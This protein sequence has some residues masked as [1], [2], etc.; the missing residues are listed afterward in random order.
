MA[1]TSSYK[2]GLNDVL[3]VI[4]EEWIAG[5]MSQEERPATAR[6]YKGPKWLIDR[7]PRVGSWNF[8]KDDPEKRE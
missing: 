2:S 1:S 8:S 4:T 3:N 6:G 7:L 5:S